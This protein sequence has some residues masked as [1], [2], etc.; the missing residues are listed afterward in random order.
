[1]VWAVLYGCTHKLV[2]NLHRHVS[3][4]HLALSHL[5]VYESLRVGVLDAYGEHQRSASSVLCHL[6]CGVAVALHERHEACR[7]ECGVVHGRSLRSDVRQV[8]AH[9][10]AALHQL[11]LLL[12]NTHNSAVGVGIAVETNHKAVA[13]RGYLVVVANA[14]HWASCRNDVFKVVEQFK[15]LLG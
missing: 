10:S 12:V 9:A 8:V 14:C 5:C 6:A 2:V 15:Y 13:Q 3:S 7:G 4:G 11:H 1:M